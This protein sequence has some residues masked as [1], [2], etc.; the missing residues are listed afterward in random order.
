MAE[1]SR[2]A[3]FRKLNPVTYRAIDTATTFCKLRGNPYVEVVHWIHQILQLQDSDIH[4][5]VRHFKIDAS[6]L[7]ND[8]VE[9]L[10]RLPRGA[11]RKSVV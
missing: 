2:A 11:D 7:A 10:D 8:V 3:L 1:I 5:L 4:H 9:A 6:R